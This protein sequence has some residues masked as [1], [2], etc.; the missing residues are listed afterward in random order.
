MR[1]ETYKVAGRD[2]VLADILVH[3]IAQSYLLATSFEKFEAFFQDYLF[4]LVLKLCQRTNKNIKNYALFKS[5]FI[6]LTCLYLF[7]SFAVADTELCSFESTQSCGLYDCGGN[8]WYIDRSIGYPQAPSLHSG[9]IQNGGESILCKNVTGPATINFW[10]RIEG[11]SYH[12]GELF[13]FVDRDKKYVCASFK[14]ENCSYTI[15]DNKTHIISWI[16]R[17]IRSYPEYL[18]AG[19]IDNLNIDSQSR[20]EQPIIIDKNASGYSPESPS[21]SL[22]E[23]LNPPLIKINATNIIIETSSVRLNATKMTADGLTISTNT[24]KM[25]INS[26]NMSASIYGN[27]KIPKINKISVDSILNIGNKSTQIK[28]IYP[29]N[30]TEF[31]INDTISF[32]Y[33]LNRDANT[34]IN[35]CALCLNGKEVI[36]NNLIDYDDEIIYSLNYSLCKDQLGINKWHIRCF[37]NLS[38]IIESTEQR[39]IIAY[40]NSNLINVTNES[41]YAKCNFSSIDQAMYYAF[42][43][44]TIRV[45]KKYNDEHIIINKSIN[46]IAMENSTIFNKGNNPEIILINASN[47][48][49]KGFNLRAKRNQHSINMHGHNFNNIN[50]SYNNVSDGLMVIGVK[51]ITMINNTI[52]Q[53]TLRNAVTLEDCREISL[54]NNI[55]KGHNTGTSGVGVFLRNCNLNEIIKFIGNDIA[56]VIIGMEICGVQNNNSFI[57]EIISNN[58]ISNSLHLQGYD[59]RFTCD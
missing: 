3:R 8:S 44:S 6:F 32:K 43:Q 1:T 10:W 49:I 48:S 31:K 59:V 13:F 21:N 38:G 47:V 9:V 40:L 24:S 26:D 25:D 16:F 7:L 57:Q 58:N 34:F 50:I 12:L 2:Y 11:T 23:P 45:Y 22:L 46:L 53:D 36:Q 54:I 52:I 27:I 30:N 55:L 51:N 37:D 41:N 15:R 42:P 33:L 5:L 35:R 17:K 28:L 39:N 20:W 18:G 29:Q 14:G 56:G 4:K 19:W